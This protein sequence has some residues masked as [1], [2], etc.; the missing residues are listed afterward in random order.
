MDEKK[1]PIDVL[2]G[3]KRRTRE[4]RT[5][6]RWFELPRGIRSKRAIPGSG[7]S[8]SQRIH[9]IVATKKSS[10]CMWYNRIIWIVPDIQI[11]WVED[12]ASPGKLVKLG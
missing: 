11:K 10:A 9:L 3:G 6:R 4:C 1:W 7:K 5:C 8:D 12:G 2:A